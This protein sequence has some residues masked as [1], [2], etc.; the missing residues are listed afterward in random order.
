MSFEVNEQ[1]NDY[2]AE[3]QQ[4]YVTQDPYGNKFIIWQG[5]QFKFIGT[6]KESS[7]CRTCGG[8]PK[9]VTYFLINAYAVCPEGEF[10]WPDGSTGLTIR[11]PDTVF[12]ETDNLKYPPIVN[13]IA[14]ELGGTDAE[15]FKHPVNRAI[16]RK[17]GSWYVDPWYTNRTS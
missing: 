3:A 4:N 7:S 8:K 14:T 17:E 15:V 6:E 1:Y 11:V 2:Y 10:I 5:Q 12:I 16:P 13:D 9:V